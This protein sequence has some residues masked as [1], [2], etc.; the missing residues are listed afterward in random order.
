MELIVRAKKNSQIKNIGTETNNSIKTVEAQQ[1]N[2]LTID[3]GDD[4]LQIKIDNECFATPKKE[5]QYTKNS[6][7]V[8]PS[9]N[10]SSQT[11]TLK[12]PSKQTTTSAESLTSTV[13]HIFKKTI[14]NVKLLS[15]LQKTPIR[16]THLHQFVTSVTTK[17][18]Q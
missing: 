5:H 15:P 10:T 6:L 18:I 12:T 13:K 3:E 14:Q 11:H 17:P 8:L 7:F 16:S 9:A 2:D 4:V 1:H